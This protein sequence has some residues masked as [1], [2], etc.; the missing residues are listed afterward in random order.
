M[1]TPVILDMVAYVMS[2]IRADCQITTR[3]QCNI[4]IGTKDYGNKSSLITM[5]MFI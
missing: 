1:Y 2:V 5:M 4:Y 3:Y